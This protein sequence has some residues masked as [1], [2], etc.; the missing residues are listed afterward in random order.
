MKKM[1]IYSMMTAVLIAT[2]SVGFASCSKDSEEPEQVVSSDVLIRRWNSYQYE[3]GAIEFKKDGTY[4]YT[5]A[6]ETFN[7]M[8]KVNE[9][10]QIV[11]TDTAKGM[12][13]TVDGI[14]YMGGI[15]LEVPY[16]YPY[17]LFKLLASSGSNEFDQLWVKYSSRYG[18]YISVEL[19]AGNVFVRRLGSYATHY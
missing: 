7:G 2:L 12:F 15:Y 10:S 19:Y 4:S 17:T 13:I 3:Q 18:T 6:N 5:S 11:V 9:T 1:K 16:S 8:Y 14:W